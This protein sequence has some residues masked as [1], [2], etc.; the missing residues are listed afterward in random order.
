MVHM[1]AGYDLDF[2]DRNGN[3][4]L[5][6]LCKDPNISITS[7]FDIMQN[8]DA[9]VIKAK[10]IPN[11]IGEAPL[12]LFLR[13]NV[14]RHERL[15][16]IE[17][18]NSLCITSCQIN[19]DQIQNDPNITPHVKKFSEILFSNRELSGENRVILDVPKSRK[20][21]AINI[22]IVASIVVDAAL[23]VGSYFMGFFCRI[24]AYVCYKDGI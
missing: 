14:K 23:F 8:I 13:R 22:A 20:A 24:T 10:S 15:E 19:L 9:S 17:C 21:S 7:L 11:K 5:H 3:N 6:Q 12:I 1:A 2:I 18:F 4:G 16:W